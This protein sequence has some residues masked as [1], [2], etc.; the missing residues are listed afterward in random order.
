M[1]VTKNKNPR[2]LAVC[3]YNCKLVMLA[4][5]DASEGKAVCR[6]LPRLRVERKHLAFVAREWWCSVG[7]S[8]NVSGEGGGDTAS[9]QRETGLFLTFGAREGLFG[10]GEVCRRR[11]KKTYVPS[12]IW[13]GWGKKGP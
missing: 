4:M 11:E 13:E 3:T 10:Y 8:R 7:R 12:C 6:A 5:S 1:S 9:P 2:G